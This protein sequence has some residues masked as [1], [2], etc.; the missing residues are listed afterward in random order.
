M[1]KISKWLV[2]TAL[3]LLL[4]IGAGQILASSGAVSFFGFGETKAYAAEEKFTSTSLNL[5]S[6]PGTGYSVILT[7]PKG[8]VVTV[9]ST[10]NGWS[11]VTY[12]GISGYA[13]TQY[14]TSSA[15]FVT[16][17]RLNLRSG[18][19]TGYSVRLVIPSGATVKVTRISSGW[20]YL[21]YNGVTG[22][23]SMEFLRPASSSPSAPSGSFQK[24]Y[25]GVTAYSGK[26]IAITFD[27]G[28][29]STKIDQ[30]L[31][32]LDRYNAKSTFFL[33]GDWIAA[34][35]V[36]A[37]KIVSRGHKMESHSVSHPDLTSL[38]DSGVLS[39]LTRSR[40]IIKNTVGT[41][42]YLIRPPYGATSA[43]VERIAREAGYKYMVMWS[44]DTDDYKSTS[45]AASITRKAVEGA[46]NNGILLLHPNH[47]RV[48]EALPGILR[49]LRDKGYVFTT[50]NSMLP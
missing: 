45:T 37:R 8:A 49:Q 39:Q 46:T 31:D 18:P 32:I 9:L 16:T 23:S 20:A 22:Y 25:K 21:T 3:S 43:R 42:S 50:V 12:S 48:V 35:P 17:T 24:I 44:I 34:N 2:V 4:S 41:T 27:D 29:T 47:T 14:L 36:T 30:V 28:A 6:G 15:S 11:K 7:M 1:K 5:R 19:G 26:R 33:T 40:T 13:A 10:S 38:S